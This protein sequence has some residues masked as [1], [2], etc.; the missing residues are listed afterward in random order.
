MQATYMSKAASK[1]QS[2]FTQVV[3][4]QFCTCAFLQKQFSNFL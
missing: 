2:Y 1:S 4:V 3:E